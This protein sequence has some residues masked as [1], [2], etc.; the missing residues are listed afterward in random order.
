[1]GNGDVYHKTEVAL[2]GCMKPENMRQ[3]L[4]FAATHHVGNKLKVAGGT[5]VIVL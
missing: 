1:M 4:I 2:V 5:L 3:T